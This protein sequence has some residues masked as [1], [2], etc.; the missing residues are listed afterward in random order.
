MQ[1]RAS[2]TGG[3]AGTDKAA[4]PVAHP[5][6][7]PKGSVHPEGSAHPEGS[8]HPE[9]AVHPDGSAHPPP[10]LDLTVEELDGI[11][12][13]TTILSRLLLAPPEPDLLEQMRTPDLLA[14]WPLPRD[15]F[16]ERGC[17]L[18]TASVAAHEDSAAVRRDFNRLFV[19][20]D[21]LLAAPYE[22]VHR[23]IDGL[24]FGE[25]TRQ[26][27]AHY[28][29]VGLAAPRQGREPDDHVGLEFA[30]VATLASQ[31]LDA[32]EAGS[33]DDR[34]RT[35]DHLATFLSE[36]LLVWAPDLMRLIGERADTAFYRGVSALGYATLAY[37][38][39][40]VCRRPLP[41]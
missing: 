1:Q 15:A 41:T 26:V 11:A 36:H 28:A 31:A 24:V 23:S 9:G 34:A 22:S 32:A 37:A 14:D 17:E 40:R 5:T 20:P 13:A 21:V 25:H 2:G 10:A 16:T 4:P 35:L 6:A 27:R 29:G 30:F 8:V 39:D 12:A 18:L 33:T 38:A 19:G 7:H 3:V